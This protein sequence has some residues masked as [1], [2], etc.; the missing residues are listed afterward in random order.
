MHG[1]D[2]EAL[3]SMSFSHYCFF[4]HCF[5]LLIQLCDQHV[6]KLCLESMSFPHCCFSMVSLL[7]LIGIVRLRTLEPLKVIDTL[8]NRPDREEV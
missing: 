8:Q 1:N 3:E 7:V 6:G 2:Q 5:S 4:S